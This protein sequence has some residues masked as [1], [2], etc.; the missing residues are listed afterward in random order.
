MLTSITNAHFLLI[1]SPEVKEISG[2][3]GFLI[4]GLLFAGAGILI[5]SKS[6]I[7]VRR[8][9]RTS[10]D[11]IGFRGRSFGDGSAHYAVVEFTDSSGNRQQAELSETTRPVGSQ[12][13]IIYHPKWQ[14]YAIE[15][16]FFRLWIFPG[17]L[18][19][20]IGA[21]TIV[22]GTLWVLF[23]KNELPLGT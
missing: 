16:S 7:L 22:V 21:L 8:G 23:D 3:W 4:V 19:F 10:A 1:A 6:L 18:V 9:V 12:V 17:L 14:D 13:N 2:G 15:D 5:W 20:L 11:V